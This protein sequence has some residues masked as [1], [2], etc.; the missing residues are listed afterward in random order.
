MLRKSIFQ[1]GQDNEDI[2]GSVNV[3]LDITRNIALYTVV[4]VTFN[5]RE[6]F[7]DTMLTKLI[8]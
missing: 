5:L 8:D 3:L 7:L 4:L 2:E 6:G 1:I